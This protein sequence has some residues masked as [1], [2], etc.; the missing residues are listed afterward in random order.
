MNLSDEKKMDLMMEQ[1]KTAISVQ[2]HFNDLLM[3]IRTFGLT[4]VVVILGT[5]AGIWKLKL[6]EG[7]IDLYIL[8]GLFVLGEILLISLFVVDV[9]Y[10]YRL[11][12]AAVD[13][14]LKI[15]KEFKNLKM[16]GT[17]QLFGMTQDIATK[18]TKR[19]ATFCLY[20]FYLFPLGSTLAGFLIWF[21]FFRA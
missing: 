6:A 2:T 20:F 11:L 5:A 21:F 13:H 7:K 4:A 18:V 17:L 15:D 12:C 9:F 19:R 3:R 10:Y 14:V 1:W 8:I 16:E